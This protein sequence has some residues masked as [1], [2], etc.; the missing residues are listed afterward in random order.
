MSLPEAVVAGRVVIVGAHGFSDAPVRHGKLGIEIG[1][2]LERLGGLVVIKGIDEA[3]ALGEELLGLGIACGNGVLQ[4]PNAR[5]QSNGFFACR[6]CGRLGFGV[7]GWHLRNKT[8][9]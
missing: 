3:Q 9:A 5:H 8:G 4:I 1:G 2:A 6:L 7:A